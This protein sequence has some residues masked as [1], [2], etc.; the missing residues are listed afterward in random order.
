MNQVRMTGDDEA[1]TLLSVMGNDE[2]GLRFLSQSFFF[3]LG[4]ILIFKRDHA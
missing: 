2:V 1:V 4:S 3:P